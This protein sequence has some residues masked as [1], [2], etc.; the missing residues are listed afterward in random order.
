MAVAEPVRHT[1][2]A[3]QP[4]ILLLFEPGVC[5]GLLKTAHVRLNQ[6]GPVVS[7]V[8]PLIAPEKRRNY[9]IGIVRA[10]HRRRQPELLQIADTLLR[11]R[12][13]PRLIQRRQQHRGQYRDDHYSIDIKLMSIGK[14]AT[15]I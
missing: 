11:P 9:E 4:E 15:Y 8:R 13:L 5:R 12:T 1:R 2:A 6:S 14:Y 7:R 10:V 3:G